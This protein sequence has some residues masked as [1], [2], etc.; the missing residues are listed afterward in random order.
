VFYI[1]YNTSGAG[2]SVGIGTTQ[3]AEGAAM[4]V[5]SSLPLNSLMGG[6]G[7]E[8]FAFYDL[9]IDGGNIACVATCSNNSGTLTGLMN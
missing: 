4:D 8:T 9:T 7:N 1:E 6:S 5:F 3:P 2:T